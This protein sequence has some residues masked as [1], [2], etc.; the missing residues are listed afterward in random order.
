MNEIAS[1][2]MKAPDSQLDAAMKPK[3]AAWSDPPTALQIL[4]VL[5]ACIHGSLASGF[6]VRLLQMMYDDARKTEGKTHEE[7][8][9]DATWR[10]ER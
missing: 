1:Y 3:I 7:I 8:A 6:V 4:E 9:K 2:L 10:V 5:D